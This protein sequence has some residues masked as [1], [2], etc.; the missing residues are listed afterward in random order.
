MLMDWNAKS[1]TVLGLSTTEVAILSAISESKNVQMIAGQTSLS[2]TGI[3]HAL[4]GLMAKGLVIAETKG[5]RKVYSSLSHAELQHKLRKTLEG[6]EIT[7]KHK[8]G[9]KIRISKEDEFI[10]H[11]GSKEIIPAYSRIAAENK[12]ERIRAIQHHR[13]WN[14]LV[15]T[16]SPKQLIEFNEAVKKNHLIIDGM[17][18]SGAYDAYKKEIQEDPKKHAEAVRS[19]EGRMA[20]YTV[21]SD[22]FFNYDVEIWIFK[23][24]TLIINWKEEVAIEIINA[25]MTGFI[26]DMFEFVK[27]GGEKLDHNKAIRE[28]L[29]K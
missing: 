29:N 13:A 28:L 25:S 26:R 1:L 7:D 16:I 5:R 9:S 6:M 18:N 15:D 12:N 8:K 21:F 2:R 23:T 20:D 22:K 10:I 27:A 11:I 4:K 14:R 17:L 24:T 3:N 19:L